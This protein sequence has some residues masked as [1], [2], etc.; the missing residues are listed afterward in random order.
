MARPSMDQSLYTPR[1]FPPVTS[2]L[3]AEI[4]TRI[5]SAGSPLKIVLFGSRARG[6]HKQDSDIDILIIEESDQDPKSKQF[7]YEHALKGVYPEMTLLVFSM[8]HAEQWRYVP[9]YI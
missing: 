8:S 4:V 1:V 9:S 3:L 6:D 2:E 5:R 7:K